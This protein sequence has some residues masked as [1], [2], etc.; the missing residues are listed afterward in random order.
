MI[1]SDLNDANDTNGFDK[2]TVGT[3][4]TDRLRGVHGTITLH[5]NHGT[6]ASTCHGP[7]PPIQLEAA[8]EIERLERMIAHMRDQWSASLATAMVA[9]CRLSRHDAASHAEARVDGALADWDR[10]ESNSGG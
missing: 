6:M 10:A 8:A 3:S 4:L 1:M 7:V 9:T 2:R 5:V